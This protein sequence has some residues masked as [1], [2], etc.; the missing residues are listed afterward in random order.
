MWA[1][2]N[3]TRSTSYRN[4]VQQQALYARH[5]TCVQY[6][7]AWPVVQPVPPIY[8]ELTLSTASLLSMACR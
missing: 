4:T 1:A 5:G 2:A 3:I 8:L 7:E 6:H